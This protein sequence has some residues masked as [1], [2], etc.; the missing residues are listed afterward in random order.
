MITSSALIGALLKIIHP[1][2]Y[3]AGK[4]CCQKLYENPA[5]VT[6]ADLLHEVLTF[7]SAPFTAL[8]VI[9]NRKSP[10]HR[11]NGAR[12]GWPDLLVALGQYENGRFELPG[13]GLRLRYQPGTVI[14]LTGRVLQ[15]G[16]TCNGDRACISYYMK[17]AV[18]GALGED[19]VGWANIYN[20]L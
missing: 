14:G 17:E 10:F 4:R 6:K 12:H 19:N 1:E 9:A 5:Q 15:H 11:D 3:A 13:L 2:L 18:V 8:S 20:L 16:A 7:W